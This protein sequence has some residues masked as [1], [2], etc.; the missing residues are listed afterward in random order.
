M[1]C[2]TEFRGLNFGVKKKKTPL[3]STFADSVGRKRLTKFAI[4]KSCNMLHVAT[5]SN[6][7]R[8]FVAMARLILELPLFWFTLNIP[9]FISHSG[10]E[11]L[12]ICEC[13]QMNP[14]LSLLPN[15]WYSL[16]FQPQI[17]W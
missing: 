10:G 6:P 15:G 5:V 9:E 7:L 17:N 12:C 3:K 8:H 4:Q 2:L 1:S 11:L 13:I 16:S 14:G